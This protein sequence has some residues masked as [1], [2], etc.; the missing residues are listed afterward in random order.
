MDKTFNDCDINDSKLNIILT[1]DYV[2]VCARIKHKLF[3]FL[4]F[5]FKKY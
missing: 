4:E 5:V 2:C 1:T 3:S